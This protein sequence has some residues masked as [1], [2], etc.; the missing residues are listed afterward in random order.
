MHVPRTLSP[1]AKSLE[2]VLW[3]AFPHARSKPSQAGVYQVTRCH[4]SG[5]TV[6]VYAAHRM[7]ALS[8]TLVT[9]VAGGAAASIAFYGYVSSLFATYLDERAG[10][11][12]GAT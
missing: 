12:G 8:K 2:E 11:R 3:H 9:V 10:Q 4:R 7:A 5:G 1:L 6:N